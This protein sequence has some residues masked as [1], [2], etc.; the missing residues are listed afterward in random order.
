[1]HRRGRWLKSPK[2]W[3]AITRIPFDFSLAVASTQ[4]WGAAMDLVSVIIPTH[5]RPTM[6]R[7]AV[8]SVL[9]QTHSHIEI[10]IVLKGAT[11]L[12]LQVLER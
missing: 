8:D 11:P 12:V 1:M 9:A 7:E 2:V 6:L 10:I 3:R 4:L 5:D